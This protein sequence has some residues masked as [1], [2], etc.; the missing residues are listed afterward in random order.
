LSLNEEGRTARYFRVDSGHLPSMEAI[1][2][3]R[4]IWELKGFGFK[5]Y[6]QTDNLNEKG[7]SRCA[8]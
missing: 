4:R 2:F 5:D 3:D 7:D 1:S 8:S 6:S